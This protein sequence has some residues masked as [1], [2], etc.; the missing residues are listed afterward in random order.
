MI[1]NGKQSGS[2][3]QVH[4]KSKIRKQNKH[5]L[6]V[7]VGVLGLYQIG[8]RLL[9]YLQLSLYASLH[10]HF[11][12]LLQFSLDALWLLSFIVAHDHSLTQQ[13]L[14]SFLP[15]PHHSAIINQVKNLGMLDTLLSH[16][17][18]AFEVTLIAMITPFAPI[19]DG[20]SYFHCHLQS[21]VVFSAYVSLVDWESM[22]TTSNM[23]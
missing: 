11:L 17:E 16:Y 1:G 10:W 20:D 21:L 23:V 14:I 13:S 4:Q 5:F 6:L 7:V 2:V 8:L 12:C 15:S 22:K 18:M 9:T 3:Q 19:L